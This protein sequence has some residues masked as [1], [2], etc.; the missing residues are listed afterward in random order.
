[1]GE[2][3]LGRPGQDLADHAVAGRQ[4]GQQV[5]GHLLRGRAGGQEQLGGPPVGAGA[6]IG[7]DPL[8]HGRPHDRMGELQRVLDAQQA[9]ADQH[10]RS[11][12]GRLQVEAG[13]GGGVLELGPVPQ[14]G[15]RSQQRVGG[16]G[17]AGQP[18]RDR[19]GH[20]FR[21][22]LE[23]PGGIGGGRREAFTGQGVQQRPHIQRIAAGRRLG[24]GDEGGIRLGGQRFT[25]QRRHR[26]ASQRAGPQHHR[27]RVGQHLGQQ[28]RLGALL[29]RP[30]G[31]G[32]QQRQP[33]QPGG[34]V[35]D[36]SQRRHVGPVQV[37][38]GQ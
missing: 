17:Q 4:R 28:R 32:D 30:G 13:E 8:V 15:G 16:G 26:C 14:H 7:A 38:D 22:R 5:R 3:L 19:P 1:L 6:L 29:G 25:G 11:L 34:Q 37:V 10:G 27:G 2:R 33:F 9:G 20:R 18:Q 24:G 31:D 12:G 21:A 35:G 36:P 23:H